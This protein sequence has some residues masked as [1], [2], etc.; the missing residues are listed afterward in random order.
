[1]R[2]T[3]LQHC[4]VWPNAY[5]I[6]NCS[7]MDISMSATTCSGSGNWSPRAPI[8][9]GR[10]RLRSAMGRPGDLPPR[11]QLR[12]HFSRLPR[13]GPLAPRLS[14]ASSALQRAGGRDR[15]TGLSSVQPI[16]GPQLDRGAPSIA[17]RSRADARGGRT[18]SGAGDGADHSVLRRAR[19]GSAR[20]GARHGRAMRG[21]HPPPARGCRRLPRDR[22]N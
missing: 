17:R 18:G 6:R 8:W 14:R 12:L 3:W 21:R 22:S 19:D 20:L 13:A 15:R 7:L 16:H 1:M 10:S 2:L 9:N 5:K 11:V 4:W